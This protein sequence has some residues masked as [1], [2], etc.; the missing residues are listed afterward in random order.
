MRRSIC[1]SAL[2]PCAQGSAAW[3]HMR[4][5]KVTASRVADLV[6]RTKTG[7]SASRAAYMSQLLAERL[8]GE[9]VTTVANSAMRWGLE[10]EPIARHAYGFHSD[11]DVK[12]SGFI[13]HP[14][15]QMSGASPDGLIGAE[16]LIEIKCPQ[17]TTHLETLASDRVPEKHFAQM[18]WQM[19][20]T[21]R[22]WCDF[23][24]FDPRLP[25]P[26]KIFIR[27]VERDQRLI[28]ELELQ[29]SAFLAELDDRLASL[30]R[31]TFMRHAA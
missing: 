21:G 9:P 2:Q 20:C 13:L 6:A 15:I 11:R 16:G 7:W 28:A 19:A 24:S 1:I 23:V 14:A 18:Q 8:T 30:A 26:M 5:G 12:S 10:Q 17:T 4:S 31:Y 22:M 27:T 25:E 29:V 3:L